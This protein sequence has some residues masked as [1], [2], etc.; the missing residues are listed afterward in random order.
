MKKM[1]SI[2]MT[3][4]FLL[5]SA[6]FAVAD[7]AQAK[8]YSYYGNNML[9]KQLD[10]A[11]LAGTGTPGANIALTLK[12]ATGTSIQ[13]ANA[14]VAP[15]GTFKVS[16]PAPAGG[17]DEYS[18]T[19]TVNNK[20]FAVL[21]GVVF[22]ELWLAGGQ[23]NMQMPLGQSETGISMQQNGIVG[24]DALRFLA[25][26]AQGGYDGNIEHYPAKPITD[27]GVAVNWYKGTDENVY[28]LSAVGYFFAEEMIEKLD[29][30][31]GILN[32]NLGGTSILTW[33]SREA[34]ENDVG[35]LNDCKADG[36]YIALA[37]WKEDKIN[38]SSD[39]TCNFNDKIA[40]LKNFRL[41]GMIWYQGETDL[42]W[43]N[44]QYTRAFNLLQKSYTEYFNYKD[45]L[46]PIV[47]T[48]LA[49]YSYGD[50]NALQSKNAEFADMQ[51]LQPDSR[52]MTS[53]YDI[54]LS[55]DVVTHA[56]HPICKQEV[57]EK[58][59][60][61]A[62]G[63]VYD[64]HDSYS[65]PYKSKIVY[66]DNSIYV[67]LNNIGDGLMVDGDTLYGFAICGDDGIYVAADAQLVS[68]D[69]VRI[70]CDGI[71]NPASATYA[72]AQYNGKANL[73]ASRNG[74]K[75]LAVSPFITNRFRTAHTW[76]N[77]AWT[78]CDYD[79]YWHCHSNEYSGFYNTWNVSNATLRFAESSAYSGEKGLLVCADGNSDTFSI[80]PNFTYNENGK[81]AYF[82][83]AD[84]NWSNYGTLS[85]KVR[86]ES[87]E[88]VRFDE[89]RIETG[90]SNCDWYTAKIMDDAT[91]PA[92]GEWHTVT[93][94]LNTLY[95][96]GNKATSTYSH[97]VLND[98]KN[99]TF[100]FADLGAAGA[101]ISVD[102]FRFTADSEE[103]EDVN[104]QLNLGN[105]SSLIAKIKAFFLMIFSRI[106]LLFS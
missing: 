88:A 102:D 105:E 101:D 17:Y 13:T 14:V 22:G 58:M 90:N 26:P 37:D 19:L 81:T 42:F 18:I 44:G 5:G 24:S 68:N 91:I 71:E 59:A 92:D 74:E 93:L 94:D 87:S 20:Q 53:I 65:A 66:K 57:G 70:Y 10:E 72:F 32:A 80:S 16:F 39:M 55:Y 15:D 46:L 69:T 84:L 85:F 11:V 25:V 78:N 99:V 56:I 98:V 45:G 35:V 97:N 100:T 40:P 47:Y 43:E 30:P 2:L 62:L 36:R 29:M 103:R 52:A 3:V 96:Q 106:M 86:V 89:L 4:A 23:S 1:L 38:F 21:T 76:Q 31:V 9:F 82:Q 83:D 75:L 27:Y 67:T 8:L 49:S 34:I 77:E 63:L 95:P 48:Q 64:R 12:N 51:S 73:F 6:A 54:P 41:S 33:L 104:V 60:Y 79:S 50:A 7:E 28:G 61:A